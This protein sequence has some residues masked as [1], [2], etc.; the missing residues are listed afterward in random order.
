MLPT[1]A[2]APPAVK[3]RHITTPV[4]PQRSQRDQE[5]PVRLALRQG[6]AKNAAMQ[7]DAGRAR[8]NPAIGSSPVEGWT[9]P[10]YK[11]SMRRAGLRAMVLLVL[12]GCAAI[13]HDTQFEGFHADCRGG[14]R[15]GAS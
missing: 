12:A 7:R 9:T 15:A 4:E 14:L 1:L 6:E 11:R 10:C 13:G 3:P 8:G 2:I 5:T